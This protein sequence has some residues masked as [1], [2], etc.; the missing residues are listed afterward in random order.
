MPKSQVLPGTGSAGSS[1]DHKITFYQYP[2]LLKVV[3][4]STV[5]FPTQVFQIVHS[6]TNCFSVFPFPRER[7]SCL[8]QKAIIATSKYHNMGKERSRNRRNTLQGHEQDQENCVAKALFADVME[9]S[10]NTTVDPRQCIPLTRIR[11][12][13][14]SGVE[15][16]KASFRAGGGPGSGTAHKYESGITAGS[17]SPILISL[18]GVY[19]ND[20][21]DHLQEKG[22]RESDIRAEMS[23]GKD[24]FGVVDGA[25]RILAVLEL[26]SENPTLWLGFSCP[27]LF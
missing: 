10:I 22:L 12:V 13:V 9:G 11:S 5:R 16:L 23:S 20:L 17:D 6:P 2:V 27:S 15:R 25:H 21:R 7:L 3:E 26:I 1:P 8:I 14:R 4:Q 18:T 24:W 19:R